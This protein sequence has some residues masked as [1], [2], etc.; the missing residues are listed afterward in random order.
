MGICKE[1]HTR[2]I[3][4][5][6]SGLELFRLDYREATVVPFKHAHRAAMRLTHRTRAGDL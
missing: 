5:Y 4:G 2:R 1:A 3:G 6:T